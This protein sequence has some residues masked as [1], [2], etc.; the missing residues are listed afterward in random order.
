MCANKEEITR[1]IRL[2]NP[3]IDGYPN[4]RVFSEWL[5]DIE[6]YCGCYEMSDMRKIRFAWMKLVGSV[7]IYWTSI[8]VARERQRKNPIES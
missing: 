2:E 8:E 5:A 6:C 7:M 4:S 3:K 1:K